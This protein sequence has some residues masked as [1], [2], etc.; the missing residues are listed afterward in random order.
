MS[1]SRSA[2]PVDG[3][4]P[5]F[6]SVAQVAQML[7]TST[8]TIYRA[9]K[10]GEFPVVRIRGRLIVPAKAVEAMVDAAWPA[11]SISR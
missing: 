9:I 10:D 1:E 4:A 11:G 8:M 7:G 6:Y 2:A 3:E 5:R